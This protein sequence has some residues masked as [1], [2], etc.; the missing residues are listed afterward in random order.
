VAL[1]DIEM[2]EL[3]GLEVLRRVREESA[4]AECI[5]I[6]GHSTIDTAVAA[7]RL[8]AYDYLAKPYRM[9]E[10]DLLVRRACE[11]RRM[12]AEIRRTQERLSRGDSIRD[13]GS[14]SPPMR[15]AVAAAHRAAAGDAPVLIVGEPGSG[16]ESMARLIHHR[17]ARAGGPLVTVNCARAARGAGDGLL[18]GVE[19]TTDSDVHGAASESL[20][21]IEE[22]A[23]GTLVLQE[24]EYLD[25]GTQVALG[26]ALVR[27]AYR[28]VGSRQRLDVEA[29]VVATTA[30]DAESGPARPLRSDL[31]ASLSASVI[32][33]P[34]LRERTSDIASLAQ[35]FVN[36]VSRGR[37]IAIEPEA[38]TALEAYRWPGNVRELRNVIE[39][40]VMLTSGG[41]IRLPDLSIRVDGAV[42]G[43]GD[44]NSQS[45]ELVEREHIAAVL[46]RAD[47]HQ[48]RAA[49]MLGISA[50]TL[51]RKIRE[52]GFGRPTTSAPE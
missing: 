2:P 25:D 36:E 18:F 39:R 6:T 44:D 15:A 40:A 47:W 22:A 23:A 26:E 28:R 32:A 35:A 8:G 4:P 42:S 14:G 46:R 33:V 5:I 34:P 7:V 52:Y 45:L 16:R 11:K 20:G 17:S 49:A 48:G 38:L 1:L 27:G 21:Q 29:R 31:L 19:R 13:M 43:A 9:E 3:D 30:V 12:S 10:I 37:S 24:V 51:Y 41:W 50:K